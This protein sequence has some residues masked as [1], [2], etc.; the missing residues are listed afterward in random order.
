MA[1]LGV[2]LVSLENEVK[3]NWSFHYSQVRDLETLFQ[4][5]WIRDQAIT[6]LLLQLLS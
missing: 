3:A 1:C 5:Y 2:L 4:G 6:L